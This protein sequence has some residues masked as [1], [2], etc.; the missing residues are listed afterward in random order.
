MK[1]VFVPARRWFENQETELIF[2]DRWEVDNLTTPGLEKTG[3]SP[4]EIADR[5]NNPIAG[6][7]LKQLAHGKKQAVIVFDDMTR[8][9]PVK[10]V[11][12]AVLEAL[13]SA[14]MT[15]EQIRFIWALGLH[16]TYGMIDARKKL[17]DKI[18]ENY[19]VYNHNAFQ[20]L[21]NAGTTP[22]GMELWFNREFMSCDLK[23]AI[24]CV[25]PHVQAG[26]GGGAKTI[27]PGVAG[28]ETITQ[29]HAQL[30]KNP[31]SGG[32][33]NFAGNILRAEID[34]AGEAV[35]LDYK[36][37]CLINRRGE[38]AE[39]FAGPFKATHLAGAEAG[40]SYYGIPYS[41]GY[42]IAVSNAYGKASESAIAG[43]LALMAVKMGE[44][45][46][47]IIMDSPEGQVPHYLFRSW[48]SDYG[49]AQYTAYAPGT[50]YVPNVCK[51]LIILNP[52][53]DRTC[54]DL[55]CH[56]DDITFARSW[57]EV[58]S[59]LEKDYPEQARVAV[60][61]DGTMQYMVV[62]Q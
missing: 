1:S 30:A 3:L 20:H 17:G 55:Y 4:Q 45:S 41:T 48:G 59:I 29:F 50:R 39:L 36:I 34:A 23:I 40:Q 52:L 46:I 13:H 35:G 51:R 56:N 61:P 9:T 10:D 7:D 60:I 21:V 38:I 62:P 5:V 33:G 14:G 15:K 22:S 54:A 31:G 49:G 6:P 27:L 53:P 26:F 2:P 28:I 8:P 57:R 11:A 43:L 44:G 12:G 19:A 37:D 58:I 25:T 42:D 16:G 24:G 47:V 18:L 32:L